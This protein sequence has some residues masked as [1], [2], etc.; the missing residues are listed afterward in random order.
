ME[1]YAAKN[2][3]VFL[4]KRHYEDRCYNYNI[5]NRDPFQR[6]RD[7]IIHSRAFRRMMH[8]TQVF[9]ANKGG[10]LP[11]SINSYIGSITDCAIHWK[12]FEIK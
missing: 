5:I 6:D 4:T 8:K 3:S 7:R 12:I 10:P 11:K 2:D 1:I 9:N